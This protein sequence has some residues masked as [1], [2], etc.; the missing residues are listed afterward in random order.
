[1]TEIF[2]VIKDMMS[3]CKVSLQHSAGLMH[4]GYS[5]TASG[6]NLKLFR[7]P[8]RRLRAWRLDVAESGSDVI[9][10][11]AYPLGTWRGGIGAGEAETQIR[12]GQRSANA[13]VGSPIP[14]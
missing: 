5:D 10:F 9:D 3:L 7:R 11:E 4:A 12:P 13:H 1:M 8:K 14:Q 6:E 2:T